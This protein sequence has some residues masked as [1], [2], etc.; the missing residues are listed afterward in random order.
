MTYSRNSSSRHLKLL[1][2]NIV[3]VNTGPSPM[4]SAE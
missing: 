3:S 1:Q 4:T 2:Y